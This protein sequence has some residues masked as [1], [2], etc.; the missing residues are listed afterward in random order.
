MSQISE[1][2]RQAELSLAAYASLT[3][4]VPNEDNL[5]K[6]AGMSPA[7]ATAFAAKWNVVDQYT[8]PLTG[9]S[10]T[11]FQA[12]AG[13]PKHLAIRGTQGPTDFLSNGLILLGFPPELT[14]Q[15]P[16]LKAQVQAWLVNGKLSP[17]FTVA[18][19]SLG[20][21]LA[22][23]L[24]ADF[25]ASVSHAYLYNTPGYNVT[26]SLIAQALGFSNTPDASK[27]TNFRA[28]AGISPIAALGSATAPESCCEP[29]T[30][31]GN[32]LSVLT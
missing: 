15:Y 16:V 3:A 2:F 10:A 32:R 26:H 17:G 21:F 23:G 30:R 1:Y 4:G 29:Y 5:K 7:Q 27:I 18:G 28:D 25:G 8:D 12:V 31:Y 6:D 22:A 11:V 20:G 13:G 19:H 9:V 14:F 24:V